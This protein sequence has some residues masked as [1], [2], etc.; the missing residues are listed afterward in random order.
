MLLFVSGW[1]TNHFAAMLP[2]LAEAEGLSPTVLKGAFGIYAL[3]LLPGLLGG[4]NLS[5]RI[6]RRPIVLCGATAAA[7]GNALMLFWHTEPG[8]FVGRLV[9]GVGVGLA[10]SAGTA[11]AADLGGQRG[12]TLAGVVL[13]LGFATGP[14]VTGLIAQFSSEAVALTLPFALTVALSLL[15]VVRAARVR[16]APP[17]DAHEVV[18]E[19]AVGL[20]PARRRSV[21]LAL[22]A[23]I[24]MALW[25]FSTVTV[26]IIVLP[27]RLGSQG[28]PA[29][30]GASAFLALG[31]GAAIQVVARRSGWDAR[32]GV[33]GAL[34][35]GLG[36][37]LAAVA[38][39]DPSVPLFLVAVVVL[40]LAYGLCLRE[41]L[42]DVELLAPRDSRGLV[43]GIFYVCTYLGF[44]LPVLLEVIEPWAGLAAPLHVL[45]AAALTAAVVRAVHLRTTT[46]LHRGA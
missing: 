31:T 10:V 22:G 11:W 37:C 14:L 26:A 20:V 40:G 8:V 3:G 17:A 29:L 4:G 44:G 28:G 30:T 38:G 6:G 33:V 35:A 19:E 34:L 18:P 27:G 39:A 32:A 23:S 9:V 1:A 45:A 12:A 36:F 25:V 21:A 2:V 13:M 46:H 41:G 42:V 15:A 16:A 7:C 43:I 24:P 5:D